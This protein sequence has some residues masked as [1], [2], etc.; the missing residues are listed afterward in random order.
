MWDT[1]LG[2]G[3]YSGL[4]QTIQVTGGK[5]YSAH[6]QVQIREIKGASV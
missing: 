3:L 4:S 2:F 1:E 5:A 6:A